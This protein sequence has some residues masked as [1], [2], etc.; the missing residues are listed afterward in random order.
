LY[1]KNAFGRFLL[2][3][4]RRKAVNPREKCIFAEKIIQNDNKTIDT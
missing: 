1:G 3:S 4:L 2:L